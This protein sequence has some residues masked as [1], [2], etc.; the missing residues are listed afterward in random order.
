[1]KINPEYKLRSIA[2]ETIVVN[3]GSVG[4]DMTHIISLNSSAKILYEELL[5]REFSLEDA[6]D[7]LVK[8]YGIERQQALADAGRWAEALTK[9]G[10]LE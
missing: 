5:G 1:M 2:G 10:I 9:A 4:V 8:T 6:A 7:V 3:Q